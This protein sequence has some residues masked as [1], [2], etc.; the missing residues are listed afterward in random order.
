MAHGLARGDLARC[1]LA[2]GDLAAGDLAIEATGLQKSYGSASVLAGV[3]LRVARGSVFC[4]LGPNGAGKTNIGNWHLCGGSKRR[5]RS[6][7]AFCPG[8][9]P[10]AATGQVRTL[11]VPALPRAGSGRIAGPR[12]SPPCRGRT[13]SRCRRHEAA[14]SAAR[15]WRAV[16][17]F[18]AADG[19]AVASPQIAEW[20]DILR[21]LYLQSV[22][23]SQA[24]LAMRR[25]RWT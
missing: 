1:G 24:L 9:G 5:R 18:A 11:T 3:D 20:I 8:G 2:T 13:G 21:R 16:W 25:T 12:T 6:A 23:T 17:F 15:C 10:V 19:G 22:G 4:L 7:I 14:A